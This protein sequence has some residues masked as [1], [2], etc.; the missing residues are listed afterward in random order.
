MALDGDGLSMRR[1]DTTTVPRVALSRPW[2]MRKSVVLPQPLGPMIETN[3]PARTSKRTSR[4]ASGG[5]MMEARVSRGTHRPS[6]RRDPHRTRAAILA[7]ATQEITAKGL[8]GARV[9]A[10]A[11]RAGVNKRMIY[12]Y[13]GGKEGL[14]LEVLETT[15]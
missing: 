7:A 3:S 1:P 6:G 11:A 5:Q 9:D 8:N 10:I 13:F 12:H 15:Y 4:S 14:Y 2:R